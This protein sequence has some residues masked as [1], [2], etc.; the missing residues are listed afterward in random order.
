MQ[1]FLVE[2]SYV[3]YQSDEG[4]AVARSAYGVNYDRLAVLKA[5]YDPTN[6]FRMNHNISPAS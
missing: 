2:G 5:K 1:P 6:F 4:Q 3:N